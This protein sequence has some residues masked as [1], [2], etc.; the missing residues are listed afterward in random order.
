MTFNYTATLENINFFD[1]FDDMIK[2][3]Y[4][5]GFPFADVDSR[6]LVIRIL[7]LV[8]LLFYREVFEQI[9]NDIEHT[10]RVAQMK[11]GKQQGKQQVAFLYAKNLIRCLYR[12]WKDGN[13]GCNI[14]SSCKEGI[15]AGS[16][17]REGYGY[18]TGSFTLGKW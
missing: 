11:I 9:E 13:K 7:R 3:V 1:G 6:N 5:I 8:E 15:I 2:E 10:L 18:K 17:G 12:R 4:S 14:R 16:V